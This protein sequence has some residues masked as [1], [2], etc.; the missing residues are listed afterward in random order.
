MSIN[1][2]SS[3]GKNSDDLRFKIVSEGEKFKWK[4]LKAK[5]YYANKYFYSR[6]T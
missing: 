4:I 1:S 6:E 2:F 3:D 5:A